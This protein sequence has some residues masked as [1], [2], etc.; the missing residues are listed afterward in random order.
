MIKLKNAAEVK[1][2]RAGGKRLAFI[3]NELKKAV[4]PGLTTRELDTMARELVAAEGDSPSFLNYK[5]R[6]VKVAYTAA[7][8]VSINDEVVHGI[9]GER[10]LKTGDV[11]SLDLGLNHQ[12]LFLDSAVTTTVGPVSAELEKL[13]TTTRDALHAG[14]AA[15]KKGAYTGDIGHAIEAYAVKNNY[16]LVEGLGG[17][18]VGHKVHED[19]EVPNSGIPRT[20]DKLVPGMVIAIE[21]MF[22]LGGGEVRCLPDQYTYVTVDGSL[23]AHWEHTVYVN[24]KYEGEILTK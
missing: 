9:P 1:T 11:V 15:I 22:T 18:G 7:L 19:P 13:I 8:C 2:L 12:G 6:G 16:G 23:S 3:L 20:G 14:V 10:Q 17:H 4:K 24:D 5:P 21:P